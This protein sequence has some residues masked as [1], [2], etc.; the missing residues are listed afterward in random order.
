MREGRPVY[1]SAHGPRRAHV[2]EGRMVPLLSAR[3]DRCCV[4]R[5]LVVLIVVSLYARGCRRSR[6]R[7]RALCY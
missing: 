6:R 3:A 5:R 1:P 4:P 2:V 7:C